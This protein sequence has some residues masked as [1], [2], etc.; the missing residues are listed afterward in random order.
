MPVPES[1]RKRLARQRRLIDPAFE[2]GRLRDTY[3][4]MLAAGE[5]TVGEWQAVLE[6]SQREEILLVRRRVEIL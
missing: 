2:G 6:Q 1:T 4:A 5:A 3:P